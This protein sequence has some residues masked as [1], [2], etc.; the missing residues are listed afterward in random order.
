MI[1]NKKPFISLLC[2]L[3]IF[4]CSQGVR[5][6]SATDTAQKAQT[7]TA[8]TQPETSLQTLNASSNLVKD[9][10]VYDKAYEKFWS[11]R[12]NMQVKDSTYG[13]RWYGIGSLSD[14]LVGSDWI[15]PSCDSKFFTKKIL[16]SFKVEK[17]T[18][19]YILYDDRLPNRPGWM[20]QWIDTGA[21]L[22]NTETIPTTMSSYALKFPAGAEVKLGSNDRSS[23]CITYIPVLKAADQVSN[24][25]K[26]P[27]FDST[28]IVK[29]IVYDFKHDRIRQKPGVAPIGFASLGDGTTGGL[30]GEEVTVKTAE[31]LISSIKEK[32]PLIINVSG[33]ITLEEGMY[34]VA[35][36]KT[37]R[38]VGSSAKIVQGGLSLRKIKN[39]IIQNIHFLNIPDDAV[40]ITD[41]SLHIWVDHC[42]FEKGGDGLVDISGGSSLVTV[43]WNHFKK[44]VK[45]MLIGS[46]DNSP[47][48]PGRLKTTVHH[49]FFE[50]T[51][52]RHPRVRYGRVHV[53]NNY[54]LNNG[55]GIAS[56]TEGRVFVEGNY[57][58]GVKES[59]VTSLL[60]GPKGN[61]TESNNI[62]IE[63]KKM[64]TRGESFDPGKIYK[65]KLDKP[66]RI[67]R[68]IKKNAGVKG[69]AK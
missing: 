40:K 12:K 15:R 28:K 17:E 49:N 29:E 58:E 7:E 68:K 54:Y 36:H 13:D 42:T 24:S 44:H 31:D 5:A 56:T 27:T 25:D 39:V 59:W 4:L 38:G 48:D 33:T 61:L 66:S 32:K 53:F 23:G 62:F 18:I 69:L 63:T 64:D 34:I 11:L 26:I 52:M 57:F 65:Y 35:S 20:A 22:I 51:E 2:A 50:G 8:A 10:V 16:V 60:G 21:D 9:M 19:V 37:I 30:G 3:S 55:Y 67:V 46:R 47:V 14:E 43:S 45:T 6:S 41:G 1:Q